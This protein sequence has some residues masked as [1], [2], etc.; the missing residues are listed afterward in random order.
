[1][2][3]GIYKFLTMC[4]KIF[5]FIYAIIGLCVIICIHEFGHFVFA[6]MFGIHTPTFSIGFGPV[7]AQ[8]K[9]GKTNFVLSAIPLGGFVEIAGLAEH[10][11]GDQEHAHVRDETSF[12]TKPYWQKM[13]VMLG[14]ITFNMLFAYLAIIALLAYGTPKYQPVIKDVVAGSA[15]SSAGLQPGDTIRG[16]G[17]WDIA[18]EPGDLAEALAFVQKNSGPLPLVI[19]REGAEQTLTVEVP[20]EVP[21]GKGKLGIALDMAPTGE[22]ERLPFGEA[23]REGI[24]RVHH[25][26]YQT[27]AFLGH[28][29]KERSLKGAGGPVMIISESARQAKQGFIYLLFLLAVISINLAII[30]L[31]PIPALDG[32]QFVFITVEAILGREIPV[33]IKNIMFLASWVFLLSLIILF[34]FND[35]KSL[36]GY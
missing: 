10:G 5:P 1:M 9:I 22:V 17:Q 35:I 25:I 12:A 4:G 34:T 15:A 7:L 30:N 21:E 24:S 32:G 20:A 11:Q 14:G 33:V 28:L 31:I 13:L 27:I 26:T 6:K 36:L 3:I 23:I 29:I 18:Q 19:E 16:I 2:E 8:K